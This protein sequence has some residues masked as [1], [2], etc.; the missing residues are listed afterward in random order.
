MSD[1]DRHTI[2]NSESHR[3][4]VLERAKKHFGMVPNLLAVMAESPAVAKAYLDLTETFADTSFT[5]Q[6]QQVVALTASRL[7][8]CHYCM[9]AESAGAKAAGVRDEVLDAVRSGENLPDDRLNALAVFTE[10][11]VES[12]GWTGEHAVDAFLEAGF[13][14]AQVLE[15]VLG[16]SKKVLS[17]YVNHIAETPLDPAFHDFEWSAEGEL[18]AV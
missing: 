12:R 18:A 15:V 2:E 6:E 8:E 10:A 17:N 14:K 7:H 1:F 11:V 16:V 9:A 13:T 3:S 4:A 5:P